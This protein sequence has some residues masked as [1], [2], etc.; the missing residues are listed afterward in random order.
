MD[1]PLA[2]PANQTLYN[3]LSNLSYN[4]A[5]LDSYS[6]QELA[7]H[8]QPISL[9]VPP[10]LTELPACLDSIY[11]LLGPL[12]PLALHHPCNVLLP[13]LSKFVCQ[14]TMP[15]QLLETK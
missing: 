6:P 12:V 10:L 9:P 4:H 7:S 1:N 15:L 13:P 3:V 2:V 8:A 11:P 14:L 5:Y